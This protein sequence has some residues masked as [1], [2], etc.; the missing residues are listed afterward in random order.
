MIVAVPVHVNLFVVNGA[1]Q[2][3]ILYPGGLCGVD[4]DSFHI[5]IFVPMKHNHMMRWK[6]LSFISGE[7]NS[8][9]QHQLP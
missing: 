4:V 8:N 3:G 5:Y 9:Y 6:I 7:E 1:K 2:H